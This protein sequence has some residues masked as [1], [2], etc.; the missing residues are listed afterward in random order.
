MNAM[1]KS[2][3][4]PEILARYLENV[5]TPDERKRVTGHL[6]DC[7]ECRRT[8]SLASSLETAP[9]V[10]VQVNEVLLQR[11]VSGSRRR[12]FLPMA[13]AAAGI[14]I[15]VVSVSILRSPGAASPRIDR[16]E[17]LL[18]AEVAVARPAEPETPAKPVPPPLAPEPAP[19]VVRTPEPEKPRPN[20]VVVLPKE[21]PKPLPTPERPKPELPVDPKPDP[22]AVVAPAP[23]KPAAEDKGFVPI[24]VVDP[25]GDLWLKR[26]QEDLKA[27]AFDRA[28]WKDRLSARAGAASFSLEARASVMLEKGSD[29]AFSKVKSD[30]SYNLALGQ[31]LVMLDTEGSSQKWRIAFGQSELDFNN[32]NGR[33]SVE[34]RGDQMS[35]ML[36]EGAA[37]LKIGSLSKKATVG[38]EVV[39]SR[40]GQ[41]VEHKGEAL[42]KMARFDE[43]RPKLFMAFAATFDE[44]KDDLPLFPYTVTAGRLVPGPTGLYL[45]CEGPPSPKAGERMTIAGEVHPDRS[46]AVASGMVLRF[47]YRTTLPTFTVKLGKYA[48]ELTARRAG[49]WADME[50]LLRDFSFEGTPLLPTDPIDAIRFS[51]SFEKRSGQLDIDGVQFVRRGR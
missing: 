45:Q 11:V 25:V 33:L 8:V 6:A 1:E 28:A 42:K 51:V 48:A 47:R 39:L 40:E 35:A 49:Q 10:P 3:P 17:R 32:L 34:S 31:G 19:A 14:L 22:V 21:D 16:E 36:L 18:P 20:P 41:V 2:C 30:D 7:D 44:K 23:L 24:L 37:E 13:L 12:R 27:G 38:Q 43:L 15:G 26:D 50:V 46:F 29:V 5:L 9:A 4:E